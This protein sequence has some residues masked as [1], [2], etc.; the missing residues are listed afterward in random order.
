MR[1]VDLHTGTITWQIR[2]HAGL[3]CALEVLT[4]VH[5]TAVAVF[6]DGARF[7]ANPAAADY[8]GVT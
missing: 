2:G 7:S 3:R 6:G 8:G 1:W 5:K 4:R